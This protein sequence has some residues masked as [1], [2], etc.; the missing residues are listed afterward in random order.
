MKRTLII[1]S[2]II[3]LFSACDNKRNVSE[4]YNADVI[5]YGGTS[6]AVFA[7]VEVARSGK[8][9]IMVSPDVH[10]GGLSS[11][12]L[13][14]T[15]LGN[16]ATIGGLAREFYHEVWKHYNKP[17]SWNLQDK[18]SY[19]NRGQG[20]PAIDGDLRTMWIFEPSVAEM[21]FDKFV[22][23]NNVTVFRDEWLNRETGVEK[24]KGK[25]VA[26]TTHSGKKFI[27]KMFIDAT[28]EGD[29]LAA[30]GVSYH[31]GRE[32]NDTYNEIWN[33]VQKGVD[34]HGH[35]FHNNISAYN[36]PG[37]ST[38]GVLTGVS[39]DP[40]GE[41]GQGD[42]KVQAYCFRL[43][44]TNHA[45]NRVS[46]SKPDNY[47]STRYE[48]FL[49]MLE[50]GRP[51]R[52]WYFY[53]NPVPNHKTDVNNHGPIS[54]NNI[55]MNHDYPDASYERRIEII[56]DH[57]EYQKG[58]LWF[59]TNDPR[60]PQE[61]REDYSNWGLS[62]DEFTDNGNWPHQLYIREARRMIGQF[63]LTENDLL[64]K[65]PVTQSVGM[66]SYGID[67]HNTQRYITPEGYVQNEGDI[68]VQ[69]PGPY[70]IPYGTLIPKKE[71]CTNLVV[72]VC[73]SSSHIAFGSIRM[74]PVFMILG[75][76]AAVAA[77]MS[78][79]S[80]VAVQDLEYEK[81]KAELIRKGQILA[82]NK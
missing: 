36:V 45:S 56:K 59:L 3:I 67:S 64:R 1:F 15:D 25:I 8:L 46:F 2:F 7:A 27:G 22:S 33:G 20:I 69:L 48:L 57:E 73:V 53:F 29:L 78:I 61:L 54:F 41:N 75:Q 81:L 31:V 71:E 62:K 72:P 17:E 66:G 28:Y 4:V 51:K 14:W 76:S 55:G 37:D 50:S 34:H 40:P 47:D 70:A 5:I 52:D 30:A 58:F 63:V 74:E 16:K 32:S 23:E 26:I 9:V 80:K 68:G 24:E 12:G 82:Y 18:A 60:V 19:G 38:S 13:G 43:C 35:V 21:I 77:C 10:L 65:R 39:T 49:R 6:A 11:G 79:D 44:L 42:H